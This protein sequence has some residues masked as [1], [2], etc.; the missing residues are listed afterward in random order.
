[1]P[2]R[3]RPRPLDRSGEESCLTTATERFEKHRARL[4]GL[5]YRMLGSRADAEDV[6][7]DAWL[8]WS[9]AAHGDIQSDQAYLSTIV[10]RLC[11][12][13]LRGER[14]RRKAYRGPWL[15]EPITDAVTLSS[16]AA[17]E[18]ADDLSYA[19]LLALERLSARERAAFLLHDVF[20]V[21]F[22][23]VAA[24]LE[25]NAAAARQLAARARKAIREARPSPPVPR[26][27]HGRLL[28]AFM[29]ALNEGDATLLKTLLRE[30]AVYMNDSG[31]YRPAASRP[32]S[33]AER[34]IRLLI[35]L[36]RRYQQPEGS[37]SAMPALVNGSDALLVYV[38]RS[39]VQMW[40]ISTDGVHIT[41]V[42]VVSNP[43]KLARLA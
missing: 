22:A 42:Y 39:L 30:D 18:F 5:S 28:G 6:I 33:G 29:R 36:A 10:T 21:P 17:S 20:S 8:K 32:V 41:A 7:Q 31:G 38:H 2:T 19:L 26:E 27:V 25:G 11:L 1:M 43:E 15:P 34:I 12:D 40:T 16:Q 24:I 23:E 13:R 4:L 35:G 37:V 3:E 9:H 14:V